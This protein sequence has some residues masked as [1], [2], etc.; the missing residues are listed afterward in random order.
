M[1][2]ERILLATGPVA[3]S[4][5]TPVALAVQRPELRDK[6]IVL[7]QRL[8]RSGIGVE[9]DLR[10]SSLKSQLRRADKL[11]VSIALILGDDE[12]ARGTVQLKDLRAGEQAEVAEGALLAELERRLSGG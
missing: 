7:A 5:K 9:T 10:G 6:A 3:A 1:G 12:A 11:G 4:S 8:R 2:L